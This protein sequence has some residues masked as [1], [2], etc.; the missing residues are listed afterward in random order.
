MSN[1]NGGRE[2][3]VNTLK[4][5]ENRNGNNGAG[6]PANSFPEPPAENKTTNT[7]LNNNWEKVSFNNHPGLVYYHKKNTGNRQWHKPGTNAGNDPIEQVTNNSL[8]NGFTKWKHI[9]NNANT[10][11]YWYEN[12]AGS[13]LW[14]LPAVEAAANNAAQNANAAA[15]NAQTAAV[16]AAE[17]AAANNEPKANGAANVAAN[18]ANA[19]TVAAAQANEAAVNA[20]NAAAE[21]NAEEA[22]QNAAQAANAA[23]VAAGNAA[24]AE[25]ANAVAANAAANA[26]ANSGKSLFNNAQKK[27]N[28]ALNTLKQAQTLLAKN[29]AGAPAAGGR[30][31]TQRRRRNRRASRRRV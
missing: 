8:P 4:P 18:A 25:T 21:G 11:K 14:D 15:A 28:N 24:I 9:N 2:V 6:K 1:N 3:A 26:G 7:P 30:R 17:A 10:P 20:A 12:N 29:N 5:R 16:N 22:S 27:L 31:K 23:A 13:V 19:A